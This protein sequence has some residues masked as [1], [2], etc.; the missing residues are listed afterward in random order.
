[1]PPPPT[2]RVREGETPRRMPPRRQVRRGNGS[3]GYPSRLPASWGTAVRV[4]THAD[5]RKTGAGAE[6]SGGALPKEPG[7]AEDHRGRPD[8]ASDRNSK[9]GLRHRPREGRGG[10]E[11][12]KARIADD[13]WVDSLIKN[14]DPLITK[15]QY[16]L[17]IEQ[18]VLPLPL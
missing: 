4:G 8:G 17:A 5:A 2:S 9:R 13:K 16:E 14:A 11:F 7:A 18:A 12:R 6:G 3:G 15:K 1:M 10:Q